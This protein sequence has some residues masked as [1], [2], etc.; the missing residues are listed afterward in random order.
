[1]AEKFDLR[2]LKGRIDWSQEPWFP[3][4]EAE[5]AEY[6]KQLA[7]LRGF[8]DTVLAAVAKGGARS[9]LA[10]RYLG[11]VV[12]YECLRRGIEDPAPWVVRKHASK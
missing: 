9:K 11:R 7:W 6:R 5:R 10:Y 3:D 4:E 8:S 1:M 2:K 12:R